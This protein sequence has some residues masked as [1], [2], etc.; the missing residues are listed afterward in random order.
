MTKAFTESPL[1]QFNESALFA[2]GAGGSGVLQFV[3][4]LEQFDDQHPTVL[5]PTYPSALISSTQGLAWTILNPFPTI[6]QT[7]ISGDNLPLTLSISERSWKRATA[8]TST[9]IFASG[10]VTSNQ[11]TGGIFSLYASPNGVFVMPDL[12]IIHTIPFN[13]QSMEGGFSVWTWSLDATNNFASRTIVGKGRVKWSRPST[14]F[15]VSF[16]YWLRWSA[17]TSI[18]P[19]QG[20]VSTSGIKTPTLVSALTDLDAGEWFDVP[21]PTGVVGDL[22]NTPEAMLSKFNVPIFFE[23]PDEWQMRTGFTLL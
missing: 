2:R 7:P 6:I 15:V 21:I 16:E 14:V 19:W 11:T 12:P 17:P 3:E 22:T 4:H 1:H 23:T 13:G 18:P 20:G 10:M 9:G 5:P 8:P